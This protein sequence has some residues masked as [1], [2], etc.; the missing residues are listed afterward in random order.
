[1]C[2]VLQIV[3]L[4]YRLH[5]ARARNPELTCARTKRDQE[6]VPEVQ[7]VWHANWQ[8]YGADK[9]WKQMNR[10]GIHVARCTAERLMRKR[11]PAGVR[12]GKR[13]RTTTKN[14]HKIT[15][16]P[17]PPTLQYQRGKNHFL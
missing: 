1:M 8:V 15:M 13:I 7:W 2:K 6:L 5:A 3:L 17:A 11:G 16:S 10:E 9:V 14:R 4:C 12:R